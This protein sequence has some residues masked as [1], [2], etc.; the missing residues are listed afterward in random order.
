MTK[1]L[2]R[3]VLLLAGAALLAGT[4]L[5]A[6][7]ATL[8]YNDPNCAGF[9]ITGSGGSFTL[10]C[11]KLQCSIAG[12][13]N[14]TTAQNTSLTATCTPS[15]A[16][17]LWNLVSG[18]FS[19]IT[20]SAPSS[21]TSA[22]TAINKPS[23]IVGGQTRSCLYQVN[24]TAAPLS[25][26]AMVTVTW[27]DAL[28][29]APSGCS[30]VA[31]PA[32]LPAGGGNVTLTASCTGGGAP[33]SY[34]WTGPGVVASTTTPSQ[35]VNITATASFSVTPS[36]SGGNGNTANA[37]VTVGSGGAPDCTLQGFSKTTFVDIPW[38]TASPNQFLTGNLGGFNQSTALVIRLGAAPVGT[39]LS[40]GAGHVTMAEFGDPLTSRT[41]VLSP[42]ACDWTNTIGNP[43]YL[44]PDA[45]TADWS[46]KVNS[47]PVYGYHTLTMQ[48]G[49]DYYINVKN[50]NSVGTPTCASSCNMT[51][52]WTKPN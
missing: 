45:S 15:G 3:A 24:A 46:L 40:G 39:V 10:T 4:A 28:I 32:S 19:D 42:K 37:S 9:Q 22:T 31:A 41:V 20:C 6:A 13:T 30:L 23:G 52:N 36:N 17:Y 49:V 8:T 33:T 12:V 16:S 38:S 35:I 18:P 34:A 50:Y 27:T 43:Y 11:A 51:V 5:P 1:S 44:Q 2:I 47:A 26:Q 21:P 48:A 25:G 29:Q 14:P 7:A